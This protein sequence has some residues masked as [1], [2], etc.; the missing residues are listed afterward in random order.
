MT[1]ELTADQVIALGDALRGT[2]RNIYVL[3]E[4]MFG[5]NASIEDEDFEDLEEWCRIFH[6]E[7]CDRWYDLAERSDI[8]DEM[9]VNCDQ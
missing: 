4:Q 7:H 2:N 1:T 6:C 5:Q 3:T 8:D 9:C